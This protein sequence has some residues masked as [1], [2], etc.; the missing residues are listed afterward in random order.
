M[1]APSPKKG[2]EKPVGADDSHSLFESGGLLLLRFWSFSGSDKW[3]PKSP[4][5]QDFIP[6]GPGHTAIFQS[7]NKT[8]Y[9]KGHEL[10]LQE[11]LPL[12]ESVLQLVYSEIRVSHP[13][14]TL[15][16]P[17]ITEYAELEGT[18]KNHRA[19]TL[20]VHRTIPK[21]HHVA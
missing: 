5:P 4:N 11:E 10:N 21:A 15:V 1:V 3:F 16:Y 13:L 19:L 7:V 17:R 2:G 12:N 8:H 18:H 6:S 20:A 9:E 14:S